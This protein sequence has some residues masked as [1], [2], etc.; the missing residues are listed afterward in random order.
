MGLL[1]GPWSEHGLFD[2]R[3]GSALLR[4]CSDDLLQ[5]P[6]GPHGVS[7]VGFLTHRPNGSTA[8]VVFRRL[9]SL[10]VNKLEQTSSTI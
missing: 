2:C 7:T 4:E 1:G 8:S 3:H 9:A 5:C 6:M 10:F